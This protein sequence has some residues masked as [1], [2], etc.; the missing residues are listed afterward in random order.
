MPWLGVGVG[1]DQ[2]RE[3]IG[4]AGVRDP[5]LAAVDDVV[6]AVTPRYG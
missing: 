2:N 5:C 6:V 3:G 4:V 1:L